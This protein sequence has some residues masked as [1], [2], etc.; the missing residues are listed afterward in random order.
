MSEA[1]IAATSLSKSPPSPWHHNL[2]R[3]IFG[4]SREEAKFENRN[5]RFTL[6][7]AR[8]EGIGQTFVDGYNLALTASVG[9]IELALEQRPLHLRG[10]FAEG[11][12]MG[13]ALGDLATP[14]R[15]RLPAL[16][17]QIGDRYA[18]L[19]YVGIGW[20]SAR[21]PLAHGRFV[22]SLDPLLSWLSLDGR[23]FHDGYFHTQRVT[24]GWQAVGGLAAPIYDQGVGRSLW[25]SCGAETEEI[26]RIIASLPV[27]RA[28]DLWAG[29]GLAAVYAGGV[30]LD[31]L[32]ALA[33]GQPHRWLKQGAGFAIS[34]RAR[35][36][37]P[38]TDCAQ[39]AARITG[40]EWHELVEL[41]DEAEKS[42]R[43]SMLPPIEQYQLWR[44]LVADR[45]EKRCH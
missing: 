5:F 24:S 18:H 22:R 43:T 15:N 36:G 7:Q 1:V 42:A 29:V 45:L 28:N 26:E 44:S 12:A 6:A 11:A 13:T 31:R 33:P 3:S 21:L 14:W 34:A 23:G 25:F 41:V 27:A 30:S 35:A 9:S 10:F 37:A 17:E 19:L 39:A 38:P 16:L 4:I 2:R 20:A 32:D 8:L 40:Y